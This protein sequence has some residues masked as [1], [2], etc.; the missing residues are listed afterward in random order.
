MIN[1]IYNNAKMHPLRISQSVLKIIKNKNAFR[2]ILNALEN[3][4]IAK[5]KQK[6]IGDFFKD[7]INDLPAS[8]SQTK[9]NRDTIKNEFNLYLIL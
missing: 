1:C 5:S 3:G 2:F 9:N 7:Y 6:E 8:L 4:I